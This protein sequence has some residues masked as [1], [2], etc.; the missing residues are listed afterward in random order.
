MSV[1]ENIRLNDEEL[2]AWNTQ[3]VDRALAV[4]SSDVVWQDT[5]V[6]EPMRGLDAVRQYLQ[7]WFT[8]FPDIRISEKNRVVAEDQIAVELEFSG[9]NRGP[10]QLAPGAPAVP[11]TGK[12]VNSRGTYFVRFRNGK[13]VEVHTYPD[14]AGMM[15]QLGLIPAPGG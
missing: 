9:T 7:G 4:F 15:M 11:A 5:A 3:D 8:A 10:L 14:L 6:P 2:A 1:E 12:K 13:A